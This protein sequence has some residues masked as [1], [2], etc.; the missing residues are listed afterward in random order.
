MV[1]P[2]RGDNTSNSRVSGVSSWMG[3]GVAGDEI[4]ERSGKVFEMAICAY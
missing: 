1:L 2:D 4:G 3:Q